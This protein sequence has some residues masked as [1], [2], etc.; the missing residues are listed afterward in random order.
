MCDEDPKKDMILMNPN[1]GFYCAEFYI[2]AINGPKYKFW[3]QS[4]PRRQIPPTE[5]MAQV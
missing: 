2:F 3:Y 4:S 1:S 5:Q